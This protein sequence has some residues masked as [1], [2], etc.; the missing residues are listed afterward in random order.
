MSYWRIS[1][2]GEHVLWEGITYERSCL[3]GKHLEGG[4]VIHDDMSYEVLVRYNHTF[5]FQVHT[6][7][8]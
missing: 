7:I 3:T 5:F 2:A 8:L 1:L 4:N 6:E